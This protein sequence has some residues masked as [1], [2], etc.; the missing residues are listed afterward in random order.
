MLTMRTLAFYQSVSLEE[1][2]VLSRCELCVFKQP[3]IQRTLISG[4]V[5]KNLF[6]FFLMFQKQIEHELI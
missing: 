6:Q 1:A 3:P 4:I 5:S 2:I